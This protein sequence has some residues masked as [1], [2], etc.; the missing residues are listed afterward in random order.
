MPRMSGIPDNCFA[1]RGTIVTQ[2]ID[3]NDA[4]S[5]RAINRRVPQ[6]KGD[7]LRG[8]PTQ[9]TQAEKSSPT[10]EM[11]TFPHRAAR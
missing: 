8:G 7:S 11:L 3:S 9:F 6:K 5:R 4:V 2:S 10:R 1:A